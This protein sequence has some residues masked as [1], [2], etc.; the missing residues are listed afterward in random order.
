MSK[1][2]SLIKRA[3]IDEAI[4]SHTCQHNSTHSI[5]QGD[6]RLKVSEGRRS[7]N[8]CL[9][10]AERFLLVAIEKLQSLLNSVQQLKCK[11]IEQVSLL[12]I[13]KK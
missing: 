8:Y 13:N 1:P 7:E 10:C 3:E 6:K 11:P 12:D 5:T 9:S 2:K 4:R